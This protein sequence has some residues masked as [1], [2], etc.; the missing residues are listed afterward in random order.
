[1]KTKPPQPPAFHA[2]TGHKGVQ[3]RLNALHDCYGLSWPQIATLV[4]FQTIPISTLARIAKTGIVPKKHRHKF[5][6]VGAVDDRNR[7]TINADDINSAAASIVR[8]IKPRSKVEAL[9]VLI[10][11]KL[12]LK[13]LR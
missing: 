8:H 7:V 13:Q 6:G 1:M 12:R 5:P 4:E 2:F 10:Q 11:A 3:E 9:V